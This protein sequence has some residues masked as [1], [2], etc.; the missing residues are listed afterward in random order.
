[1]L[2][3]MNIISAGVLVFNRLVI[4]VMIAIISTVTG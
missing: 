4:I 3:F 2:L 1:M